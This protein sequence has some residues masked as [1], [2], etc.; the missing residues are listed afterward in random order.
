MSPILPLFAQVAATPAAGSSP[1]PQI[2]L[3]LVLLGGIFYFLL[4][5]PGQKQRKQQEN[6]LFALRKGD[7]IVTAGGVVGE[8]L[9]IKESLK[10][11][12]P[13]KTLED[14]ITIKSGDTKLV[15]H[16]G[17]VHQVIKSSGSDTSAA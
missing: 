5:R 8:I 9:H 15:I 14:R 12:A 2:V 1:L 4:I 13:V 16:R 11:G 10:D 3:Q 7:E 6:S 17:R